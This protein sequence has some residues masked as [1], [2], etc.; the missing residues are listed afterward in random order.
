MQELKVR[1]AIL[2]TKTMFDSHVKTDKDYPLWKQI[3]EYA[4]GENAFV[5]YNDVIEKYVYLGL[6]NEEKSK[7][8]AYM[9]E[10]DS[11]MGIYID[12]RESFEKDWKNGEYIP[13]GTIYLEPQYVELIEDKEE[14]N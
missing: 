8:L 3:A 7:E 9:L 4:D 6:Q 14:E 13:D 5:I 1:K 11:V 12:D 10:Q 2:R